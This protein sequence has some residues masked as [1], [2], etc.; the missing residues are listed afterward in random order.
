[1]VIGWYF[2]SAGFSYKASLNIT[3]TKPIVGFLKLE[4]G[5][6]S[7]LEKLCSTVPQ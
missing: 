3:R 2:R 4:H 1:M 6:G 7:Y 5:P